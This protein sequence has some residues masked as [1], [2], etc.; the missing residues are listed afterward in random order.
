METDEA[1]GGGADVLFLTA[2][3]TDVASEGD[4]TLMADAEDEDDLPV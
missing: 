1:V 4:D 3:A 2:V